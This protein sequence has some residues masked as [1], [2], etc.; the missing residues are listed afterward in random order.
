MR[1]SDNRLLRRLVYELAWWIVRRR[2]RAN[3]N[4]LIAAGVIGFVLAGGA[5]AARS[6]SD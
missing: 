5:L 4:K 6:R 2:I 1:K 3:R